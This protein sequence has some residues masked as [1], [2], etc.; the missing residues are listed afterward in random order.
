MAMAREGREFT[1]ADK[2][3][4]RRDAFFSTRLCL[5][6]VDIMMGIAGSGGLYLSST[7]QRL[8]RDAHAANA[9]QMFSTDLQGLL[10][11]QIELGVPGPAP[12]L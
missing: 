11:G 3:G 1:M 12:A 5:E 6:A 10:F 8:F 2:V 9:H 4:Y 7:M